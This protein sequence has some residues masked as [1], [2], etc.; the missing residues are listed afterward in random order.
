[1]S[2]KNIDYIKKLGADVAI[3]YEK[4]C[5]ESQF[6]EELRHKIDCVVDARCEV[7][8]HFFCAAPRRWSPGLHFKFGWRRRYWGSRWIPQS[9]HNGVAK[10]PGSSS[11][12]RGELLWAPSFPTPSPHANKSI[13]QAGF[14]GVGPAWLGL[15]LFVCYHPFFFFATRVRMEKRIGSS[16][17][18]SWSPEVRF[19]CCP[20]TTPKAPWGH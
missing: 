4:G 9:L 2:G 14:S 7:E 13:R 1:M 3:D 5:W 16:P 19:C 18:R 8:T 6:P 15:F 17:K 10:C 12:C 11:S 20:A